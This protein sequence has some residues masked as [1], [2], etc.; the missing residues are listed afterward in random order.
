MVYR[1]EGVDRKSGKVYTLHINKKNIYIY[2]IERRSLQFLFRA[3]FEVYISVKMLTEVDK[4]NKICFGHGLMQ[5]TG[6]PARQQITGG[7]QT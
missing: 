5:N 2:Y 1:G 6:R 4:F 3:I 7:R